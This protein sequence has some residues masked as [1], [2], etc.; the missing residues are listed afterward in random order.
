MKPVSAPQKNTTPSTTPTTPPVVPPTTDVKPPVENKAPA[1]TGK[2]KLT[3]TD[4]KTVG[5]W[6]SQGDDYK[7]AV[8]RAKAERAKVAEEK[9]QNTTLDLR[10]SIKKDE[11]IVDAFLDTKKIISD[12][13]KANKTEE[14]KMLLD[15]KQKEFDLKDQELQREIDDQTSYT[16]TRITELNNS[17]NEFETNRLN[18][19]RGAILQ[20]L[21]ARGINIANI[22]ADQLLALS[23]EVGVVAFK[24][25]YDKKEEVKQ[26]I[27]ALEA[28]KMKALN[29]L[30]SRKVLNE[31]QYNSAITTIKASADAERNKIDE[32]FN[33]TAYNVLFAN[34]QNDISQ[35][36][37]LAS[38]INS[39]LTQYGVS[40]QF[41]GDFQSVLGAKSVAE[42]QQKIVDILK[43]NP[44]LAKKIDEARKAASASS[45]V[46]AANYGLNVSKE[47]FDR[48]QALY[49]MQSKIVDDDKT[50]STQQK[51][52]KKNALYNSIF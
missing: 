3:S 22:P 32:N 44:D 42:A 31:T 52:E 15:D 17:A 16:N 45:A 41:A 11:P 23:G 48:K 6:T 39:L 49:T 35:G 13:D 12:T 9:K 29:D 21:A 19:V 24:D 34:K 27:S 43:N 14:E 50:L 2:S 36:N 33:T 40:A 37:T 51:T 7:T 38:N 4:P 20:K 1:N 46:S 25:V 26:K 10:D 28:D 47:E 8:G 5:Y 18:Q 30:R